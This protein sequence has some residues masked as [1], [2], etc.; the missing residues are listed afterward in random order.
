M[1]QQLRLDVQD[2]AEQCEDYERNLLKL[3][4]KTIAY[5]DKL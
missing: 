4:K 2:M 5:R 3:E 1:I